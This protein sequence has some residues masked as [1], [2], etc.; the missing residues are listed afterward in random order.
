[1]EEREEK[2]LIKRDEGKKAKRAELEEAIITS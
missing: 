2:K 1:M